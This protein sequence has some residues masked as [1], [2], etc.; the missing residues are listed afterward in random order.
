LHFSFIY[1][2]E[3]LFIGSFRFIATY[4]V[5]LLFFAREN[6]TLF[7]Q[8]ETPLYS[9]LQTAFALLSVAKEQD[10][11]T[12]FC[13]RVLLYFFWRTRIRLSF[14]KEKD[15]STFL[16]KTVTVLLYSLLQQ[17]KTPLYSLFAQT[18]DPS[19]EVK[20]L[21]QKRGEENSCAKEPSSRGA[22]PF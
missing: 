2:L 7:C 13:T 16:S 12:L 14:A 11:S 4:D 3:F 6:S 1:V 18:K 15:P 5:A 22:I 19:R 21:L 20:I 9:L 8:R 17:I 10:P